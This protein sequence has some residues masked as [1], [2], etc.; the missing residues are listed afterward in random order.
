VNTTFGYILSGTRKYKTENMTFGL[1]FGS[2]GIPGYTEP[3]KAI[4]E[5]I[6]EKGIVVMNGEKAGDGYV[7]FGM[8]N[9]SNCT[10]M[11]MVSHI[12]QKFVDSITN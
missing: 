8:L 11:I 9:H 2:D 6:D 12:K 3:I 10:N 4:M 1:G 5:N 7:I